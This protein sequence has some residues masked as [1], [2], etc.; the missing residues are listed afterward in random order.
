MEERLA[1]RSQ[2]GNFIQSEPGVIESSLVRRHRNAVCRGN[3]D[4]L[5]YQVYNSAQVAF[6]SANIFLG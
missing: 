5:G 1:F 6:A 4:H 3:P 2:P